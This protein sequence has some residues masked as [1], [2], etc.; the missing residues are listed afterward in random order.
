MQKSTRDPQLKTRWENLIA[1][2]SERFSDGADMEVE[3][4]LYLI[5][6]QASGKVHKRL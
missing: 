1:T 4:I 2:L 5:G 6:L 3:G